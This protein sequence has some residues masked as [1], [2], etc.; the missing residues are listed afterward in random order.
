MVLTVSGFA[1]IVFRRPL[2]RLGI[3]GQNWTWGFNFGERAQRLS[4]VA[5]IAV[6]VSWTAFGALF[7]FGV[8][9]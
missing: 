2:S 8:L 7:L 1:L 9:R 5:A 4:E 3:Q 6:G